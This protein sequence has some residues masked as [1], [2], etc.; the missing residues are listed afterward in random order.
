MISGSMNKGVKEI[1]EQHHIKMYF[2]TKTH[3]TSSCRLGKNNKEHW[4]HRIDTK[5]HETA[6]EVWM[7][8]H[9][10]RTFP[11]KVIAQWYPLEQPLEN[12]GRRFENRRKNIGVETRKC[13]CGAIATLQHII[14]ECR[15][16]DKQ[17]ITDDAQ[18]ECEKHIE[19]SFMPA[20]VKEVMKHMNK[21][22]WE[23][24]EVEKEGI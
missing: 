8:K 9:G 3:A 7:N 16:N 20:E 1:V 11:W 13:A 15:L 10:N 19:Q 23:S 24:T 17:D 18:K 6:I 14:T 2:Q 5:I 4:G 22:T 12:R 21:F